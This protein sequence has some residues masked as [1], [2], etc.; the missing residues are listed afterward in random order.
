MIPLPIANI[1]HHKL[2]SALAALGVAIAVCMLVTLTALTRGSLGEV[3]DRWEGVHADLLVFPARVGENISTVSGGMIDDAEVRRIAALTVAGRPAVESAVPFFVWRC[4]I[5]GSDNNVV[6]VAPGDLPM[7]LGGGPIEPGGRAFDPDGHF[8]RWLGERLSAGGDKIVDLSPDDL[9]A[10]GGLE[11]ILDDRLAGAAG[12][13][14]GDSVAAAGH[15]FKIVGIVPD[16]ALAR[17]FMPLATAQFLF[18]GRLG[19]STLIFVKLRE[20]VPAGAA[21][22]AIRDGDRLKAE[23]LQQFRAMLTDR[24]GMMDATVKAINVITLVVAFLSI[25]VV[26]YTMVLQ[27]TR[28]IAILRSMGATGGMILREILAESLLLTAG[29]TLAG[30]ALSFLAGVVIE[31][32]LPLLTVKVTPGLLATAGGTA[33]LGGLLAGL[34]PAWW[35]MRVDVVEALTYE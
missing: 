3:A 20:G 7:L 29:G 21:A 4:R 5:A 23:P 33:I 19:R 34:Y 6:G 15:T 12:L 22:E 13:D 17:A 2:R 9:A 18:N 1:A 26:L 35:A 11:M 32:V 10:H 25:L 28:E 24:F 14:V 30:I 8:A 27:R 31:A 16:G